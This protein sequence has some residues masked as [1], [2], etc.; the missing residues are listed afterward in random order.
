[1]KSERSGKRSKKVVSDGHLSVMV[2]CYNSLPLFLMY[3]SF[4]LRHLV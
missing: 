3:N 1:M 2:A 4:R